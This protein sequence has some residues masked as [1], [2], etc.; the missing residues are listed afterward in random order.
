MPMRVAIVRGMNSPDC[1]DSLRTRSGLAPESQESDVGSAL[2]PA[3][4][5]R[6]GLDS[7]FGIEPD[8]DSAS[9]VR[10]RKAGGAEAEGSRKPSPYSLV[11][12]E[13]LGKMC[14]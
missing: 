10:S 7:L 1:S 2:R 9:A 12:G 13:Y 3:V 4:D 8:A 5:A 6:R 11:V 14:T